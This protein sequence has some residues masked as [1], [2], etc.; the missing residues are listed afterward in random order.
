MSQTFGAAT[1]ITLERYVANL[2]DDH[3]ARR[4]YR[5]LKRMEE[6]LLWMSKNRNFT[7]FIGNDSQVTD[8]FAK[9][10]TAMIPEPESNDGNHWASFG[11]VTGGFSITKKAIRMNDWLNDW[12]V[13]MRRP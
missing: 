8:F 5:Q 13:Q 4:E 6:A 1:E 10:D 2:A 11:S 12:Q 7:I 3:K 9:L